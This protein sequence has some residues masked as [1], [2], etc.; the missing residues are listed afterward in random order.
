MEAA[1]KFWNVV[2]PLSLIAAAV[3]VGNALRTPHAAVPV[4]DALA[5]AVAPASGVTLP[6][7]WGDLGA[8]LVASGVIDAEK[9][10]ALYGA[11]FT[12]D[13]ERL[14]TGTGHGRLTV[15]NENAPVVLNLLWA[16]GLANANPILNEDMNDPRY[17]GNA[18]AF[19]STGGWTLAKGSAM[20]HYAAHALVSL[21]NGEQVLV[22]SVSRGIYRPCCDNPARFPDCNHGMAMLGLLELMASEGASA[23][24]MYRAALTMNAYWFPDQYATIAR[25]LASTGRSLASADPEA[26][27]GADY[28]SASGYAAVAARVSGDTKSGTS[29]SA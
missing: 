25:Y 18:S 23:K 11:S 4:V 3:L 10:R 28:S 7:S 19:A 8:K 26:I 16:L 13:D 12:N 27:L 24:D 14:L 1:A 22:D 17:G 20:T 6:V 5:D 29:C 2:G 15:T 21:T 9:F